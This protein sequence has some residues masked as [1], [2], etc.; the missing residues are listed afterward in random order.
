MV[1][2]NNKNM[3][4]LHKIFN[5][6]Q[7][8]Y[9]VFIL[10]LLN[11][12]NLI[13]IN[14]VESLFLFIMISFIIYMFNKNMILV[15][16]TPI[17]IVNLLIYIKTHYDN[18]IENFELN[19]NFGLRDLQMWLQ[20]YFNDN[21]KKSI[22]EK[23][24]NSDKINDFDNIYDLITPVL[25]EKIYD[26][27]TELSESNTKNLE[28]LIKYLNFIDEIDNL[29]LYKE[30]EIEQ[31]EYIKDTIIVDLNKYLDTINL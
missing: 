16:I 2:K 18:S 7:I 27:K 15:L 22:L 25:N 24:K 23:Y 10:A 20:N 17:I 6:Q 12:G 14:D 5:S 26:S 13:Y 29:K 28:K 30:D 1:K 11:I 31:I 3:L 21:T 9:I 8:L 4:G 19:K